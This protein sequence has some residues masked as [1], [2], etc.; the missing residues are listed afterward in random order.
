MNLVTFL[1]SFRIGPFAIFDFG[2]TYLIAYLVGPYL[3][4]IGIPLNREQFMWLIL[5]L[6]VLIHWAVRTETPLTKMALDL[7]GYW[8]WKIILI[9]MIVLAVVRK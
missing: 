1:R 5:P 3:K 6:S 9:A 7:H 4:R 8:I 2:M